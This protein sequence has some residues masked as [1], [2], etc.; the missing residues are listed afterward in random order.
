MQKTARIQMDDTPK[1]GE[2][3]RGDEKGGERLFVDAISDS[4]RKAIEFF[5]QQSR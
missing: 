3:E 4:V 1:K 5:I 2:R